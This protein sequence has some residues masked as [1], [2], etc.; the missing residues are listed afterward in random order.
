MCDSCACA[1]FKQVLEE[2]RRD[3]KKIHLDEYPDLE[4]DDDKEYPSDSAS[5]IS[6][7]SEGEEAVAAGTVKKEIRSAEGAYAVQA[8]AQK[9]HVQALH[10]NVNRVYNRAGRS[11]NYLPLRSSSHLLLQLDSYPTGLAKRLHSAQARRHLAT[12]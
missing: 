6:E 11:L 2:E 10:D 1:D 4:W 9:D 7:S 12:N 8:H 3:Y 5:S